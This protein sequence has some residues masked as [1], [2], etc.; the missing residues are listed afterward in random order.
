M[1]ERLV[2]D[3]TLQY[4]TSKDFES[5][6]QNIPR[7]APKQV[8]KDRKFYKK[9]IL[10]LTR[11]MMRDMVGQEACED[12]PP[13]QVSA[14]VQHTFENYVKS[15]IEFFKTSDQAGILQEEYDDLQE[16]YEKT[17]S[18]IKPL[19][20]EK[21]QQYADELF[22][23]N[24]QMKT[25]NTLDKFVLKRAKKNDQNNILDTLPKKK[26]I[27]LNDPSL[28]LKGIAK[29]K[30]NLNN[31]YEERSKKTNKRQETRDSQQNGKEPENQK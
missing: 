21:G 14:D 17:E 22:M 10:D 26:D 7:P 3:L 16:G 25:N 11:R 12:D 1:S 18:E 24:I 23:K 20:E 6:V 15:S 28:K 13:L 4:L 2:N 9:R 29:K 8:R 31:K 5:K 27:K 30:N 19:I